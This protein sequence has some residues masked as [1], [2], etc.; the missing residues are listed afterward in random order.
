MK[1]FLN[2]FFFFFFLGGGGRVSF[3]R[4]R[5]KAARVRNSTSGVGVEHTVQHITIREHLIELVILILYI[6]LHV[7]IYISFIMCTI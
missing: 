2:F 7:C 4:A 6:L 1:V 5:D 3:T